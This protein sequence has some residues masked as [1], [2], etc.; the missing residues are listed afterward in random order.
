MS[1]SN[2][3]L[4]CL[5]FSSGFLLGYSIIANKI[6]SEEKK[7]EENVY[8]EFTDEKEKK[9]IINFKSIVD[10]TNTRKFVELYNR[11]IK[12][13][14][15]FILEINLETYGG[16]LCAVEEIVRIITNHS[17]ETIC[18]VERY[19]HSAGTVIA[20][21]CDKI[22]CNKY[23]TFSQ[24]ETCMTYNDI[25]V[26]I[27]DFKNIMKNNEYNKK[28]DRSLIYNEIYLKECNKN[29]SIELDIKKLIFKKKKWFLDNMKEQVTEKLF[30]AKYP[31]SRRIYGEELQAL[32]FDVTFC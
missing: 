1:N 4:S 28:Y 19:A 30:S 5:M 18:R 20:M 27:I 26:S 7:V 8:G 16:Y 13:S 25:N 22:I 32:G 15:K 17:S 10:S 9:Y 14:E 23:S 29:E 24:C 3:L 11:A 6:Y 12:E 2:I 31:H 21:V